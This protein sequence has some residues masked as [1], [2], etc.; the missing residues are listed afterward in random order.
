MATLPASGKESQINAVPISTV[1]PN[2]GQLPSAKQRETGMLEL[3]I[4]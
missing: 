1:E 4:P 3:L 2:P